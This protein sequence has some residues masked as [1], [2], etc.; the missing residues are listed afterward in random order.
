MNIISIDLE[1]L[2]SSLKNN[3]PSP[4]TES[5]GHTD[6]NAPYIIIDMV[7]GLVSQVYSWVEEIPIVGDM[8]GLLESVT[9]TGTRMVKQIVPTP[10][11]KIVAVGVN[12]KGAVFLDNVHM[13]SGANN[14]INIRIDL[15]IKIDIDIDDK[16]VGLKTDFLACSGGNRMKLRM[17]LNFTPKWTKSGNIELSNMKWEEEFI[18][19]CTIIKIGDER[20]SVEDLIKL[21][22]IKD[23]VHKQIENQVKEILPNKIELKESIEEFWNKSLLNT[24]F[25]TITD[26]LLKSNHL[27]L[28][29]SINPE[30]L[31]LEENLYIIN[32]QLHTAIGVRANPRI[33]I[34]NKVETTESQ[35][36]IPDLE[37]VDKIERKSVISIGAS[38]KLQELTNSIKNEVLDS[39]FEV[40]DNKFVKI[41]NLSL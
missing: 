41:K 5:S 23:A 11:E 27:F 37:I 26:S 34:V 18:D 22:V 29:F 39:L 16:E 15:S 10:I 19:G 36:S 40:E 33:D 38:I 6:V 3:L 12:A 21:P 20:L 30:K 24:Q 2:K 31:L 17:N 1:G 25:D 14:Q 8:F 9:R 13:S 4:L 28:K 35:P 7:E 32:N